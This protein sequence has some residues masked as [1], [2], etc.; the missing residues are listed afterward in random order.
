MSS[1]KRVNW[2]RVNQEI[3]LHMKRRKV[4]GCVRGLS[5]PSGTVY[6]LIHEKCFSIVLILIYGLFGFRPYAIPA[7]SH[8]R[9]ASIV[10]NGMQ[11]SAMLSATDGLI[12]LKWELKREHSRNSG[13]LQGGRPRGR[14]SSP[15]MPR[16]S[17]SSIRP[18][19]LWGL[20]SLL[21]NGYWMPFPR[22]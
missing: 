13:S 8:T 19:R 18:D 12:L 14:S 21:S 11:S 1:W 17:S 9:A 20:S 15:L 5:Q 7:L 4:W 16:F 10:F 22:G 3:I 6:I 2:N